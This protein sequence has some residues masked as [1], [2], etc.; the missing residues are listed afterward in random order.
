MDIRL[1]MHDIF[2]EYYLLLS[3]AINKQFLDMNHLMKV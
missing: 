3:Y 2:K 1:A